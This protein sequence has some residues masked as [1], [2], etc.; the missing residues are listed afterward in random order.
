M[1]TVGRAL[2]ELESDRGCALIGGSLAENSLEQI[3]RLHAI[4]L[5]NEKLEDI[6]GFN[7]PLG[8]F[9]S[10]IVVAFSFGFIDSEIRDDYERIKEIRNAFAH[11]QTILDFRNDA[12]KRGCSGFHAPYPAGMK[13][14]LAS[15]NAA[16]RAYVNAVIALG[17]VAGLAMASFGRGHFNKAWRILT[18]D[19]AAASREKLWIQLHP[20]NHG[21][22]LQDDKKKVRKPPPQSSPG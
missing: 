20:Q 9:S 10:K 19:E 8:N 16:R 12:V 21:N 15:E 5:T 2:H 13:E 17:H 14:Y 18:Y 6:F 7:A 4:Q 1:Q 3:I 22:P 11:S